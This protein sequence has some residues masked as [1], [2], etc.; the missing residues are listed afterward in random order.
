[1]KKT[2]Q[3]KKN[4]LGALEIALL[5]PQARTRFGNTAEDAVKSFAVP[6]FLFPLALLSF[7]TFPQPE[8]AD[9]T[10]NALSF[11]YGLRLVFSWTLFL[12]A[13]YWISKEIDR[14]E[15]FYQFVTANNWVSLPATIAFAPIAWI[16]M[17]GQYTLNELSPIISVLIY[18]TYGMTAFVAAYT[19][20]IPWELAGFIAMVAFMIND[21][22][23]NVL[24]WIGSAI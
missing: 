6:L 11:L 18:Y 3:W 16:V 15:H 22:T 10:A 20:R 12:G 13:V 19:L 17:S 23:H 8:L 14:K 2:K 24:R 9:D 1:M 5:M 7:Y 21:T 4:L